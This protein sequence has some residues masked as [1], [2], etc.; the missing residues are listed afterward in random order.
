MG[1]V[2]TVC[3]G[4]ATV[5]H[6]LTI[7]QPFTS[8]H[9]GDK[10]LVTA[11]ESHSGGGATNVGAGVA[12]LGLNVKILAKVGQ[13]MEAKFIR[14]DMQKYGIKNL[15]RHTS[16]K[17]TDFSTII[18][19]T[20]EKDRLILVHKGASQD[21]NRH[22]FDKRQLQARWIYLSSLLGKSME[23]GKEIARY[24]QQEKIRLLFNP[25]LYLA[26]KGKSFLKPI[27]DAASMLV[28]NL[29]EAQALVNTSSKDQEL[30]LFRLQKTGPKTVII[31]NGAKKLYAL[32]EQKVYSLTPPNVKV[33]HTAGAGDAFTAGVLAGML[34]NYLF[35][36]ALRLGQ[37]NAGSVVQH[38][39][40]K[41]KLLTEK[42]A[43]EQMRQFKIKVYRHAC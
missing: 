36:D 20:K 27:L 10:V 13:D 7:E 23:I 4:S 25:S 6:F 2:D 30:L 33:V 21:L 28:L 41:N 24:A 32:H 3:I 11:K 8:L 34:K 22:D 29:E 12:T 40:T 5:D 16:T 37:V 31:T 43:K 38:I 9:L 15:C 14:R 42:E 35:E 1:I 19:S 17:N 39:G 18:S 26:K